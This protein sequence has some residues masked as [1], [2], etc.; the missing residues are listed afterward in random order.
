[1]ARRAARTLGDDSARRLEPEDQPT[2]GAAP[3]SETLVADSTPSHNRDEGFT[4]ASRRQRATDRLL[5]SSDASEFFVAGRLSA[6]GKLP[7]YRTDNV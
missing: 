5:E 2:R 7:G 1:M 3:G 4:S 6:R